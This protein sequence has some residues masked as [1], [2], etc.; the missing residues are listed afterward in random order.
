M[1]FDV[2]HSQ[3][4]FLSRRDDKDGWLLWLEKR[5]ARVTMIPHTHGEVHTGRPPCVCIGWNSSAEKRAHRFHNLVKLV[6]FDVGMYCCRLLKDGFAVR[7]SLRSQGGD[8]VFA[9]YLLSEIDDVPLICCAYHREK[10]PLAGLLFIEPIKVLSIY[11]L[12]CCKSKV[13]NTMHFAVKASLDNLSISRIMLKH[14]LLMTDSLMKWAVISLATYSTGLSFFIVVVACI[15]IEERLLCLVRRRNHSLALRLIRICTTMQP[16]NILR[17]Q[18]G[19][20]Y[21]SH[22]DT[23]D[24]ESYGAQPSQRL[25][26]FLLY[27]TDVEQGG[28]TIFPFEVAR[29]ICF[30]LAWIETVCSNSELVVLLPSVTHSF[31]VLNARWKLECKTMPNAY[32]FFL[33]A[34]CWLHRTQ[35]ASCL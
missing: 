32:T 34:L 23:F 4:T 14:M 7:I 11:L 2:W 15:V 8:F 10:S 28:E 26:T 13:V 12:L 22:Y 27:L 18:L 24:P 6:S 9:H 33:G 29:T 16:F 20:K 21:D 5:I 25:A 30:Y 1:A 17:Y 19:Q 31:R 35:G 3:G